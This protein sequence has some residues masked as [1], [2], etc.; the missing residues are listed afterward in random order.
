M[1]DTRPPVFS[2]RLS[3]LIS[4]PYRFCHPP[5]PTAA[6]VRSCS[7]VPTY[8]VALD[9]V[10]DR[11]H[12]PP[13]GLKDFEEWLL[14]VEEK[15]QYLYFVLWLREYT[16]RYTQWSKSSA[17]KTRTGTRPISGSL[18]IFYTR[19]KQTFFSRKS[20]YFLGLPDNSLDYILR[21]AMDSPMDSPHPHPSAFTRLDSEV[22]SIL[23]TSLKSFVRASYANV[24]NYRA[25][26]GIVGGTVIALIFGL[27][28]LL[29]SI[30]LTPIRWV[31][32]VGWPGLA[33]GSTILISSSHGVC[34]GIYIFGD[35]RQLRNFE[36]LRP[37][38]EKTEALAITPVSLPGSAIHS[39]TLSPSEAIRKQWLEQS[40]RKQNL[41][42]SGISVH[43]AF[44]EPSSM[45]HLPSSRGDSMMDIYISPAID[46]ETG[47]YEYSPTASLHRIETHEM[48]TFP[49]TA[50]FIP[51]DSYSI[52]EPGEDQEN[53]N[54][55]RAEYRMELF[56]FQGLPV[57]EP[58]VHDGKESIKPTKLPAISTSEQ[59]QMRAK[60]DMNI[61][62]ES[63]RA[64]GESKIKS[65]PLE[66][67][68][69]NEHEQAPKSTNENPAL[70]DP[71]PHYGNV[72]AFGPLTHIRSPVVARAQ[73][74]ILA[75]AAVIGSV[76]SVGV[77]G[78]LVGI[79]EVKF[80]SSMDII[81]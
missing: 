45:S 76:I 73:W 64:P 5:Q 68:A 29:L 30:F 6:K 31:R 42:T 49:R 81:M 78:A 15:P 32:W 51:P 26:C 47:E 11:R 17:E 57:L 46:P 38:I 27:L 79:P 19:A 25:I 50:S 40:L 28:P 58:R 72:P 52:D 65:S 61:D 22:R 41:N 24:A 56:N 39:S 62:L 59:S 43:S 7:I 60:T 4:F 54:A 63:G 66:K 48:E 9:D 34:F 35:A 2:V 69:E 16:Q 1:A 33:L 75:R 21:P 77:V 14:F 12:L 13:L 55:P 44:S 74:D 80:M 23:S 71:E 37:S 10:L 70:D 18:S 53:K 20:P 8:Q 3:R 36:L 67:K